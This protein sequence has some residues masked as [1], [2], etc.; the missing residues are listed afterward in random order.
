MAY[1]V[2][3]D[4]DP[5]HDDAA[6]ILLALANTDRFDIVGFSTVCG[7]AVLANTTMNLDHLLSYIHQPT[8]IH[9][10]AD[11]PL[12]VDP[13]PQLAHGV[14]GMDGPTFTKRDCTIAYDAI[15]ALR[16]ALMDSDEKLTIFALG[17]LTNIA[18]LIRTYPQ[19]I[20]HIDRLIIMGGAINGGNM[21]AC[22]EF[23]L[24]G[25]PHAAKIVFDSADRIDITLAPLEV[26]QACATPLERFDAF[27]KDG[28]LYDMLRPLFDFY[29]GYARV[30][31]MDR[32]PIFDMI[33]VAYALDPS[34]FT[35]I[36][37]PIDIIM[38][39]KHTRGMSVVLRNVS[40]RYNVK[41]LTDGDGQWVNDT[42]FNGMSKLNEMIVK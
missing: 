8:T 35:S 36:E 16:D 41:I 24:Y 26:C 40:N 31:Q 3:F 15:D 5:G 39:G 23:N 34:K 32:T 4:C 2:W 12:I 6:A 13:D 38:E 18:L 25:D 14:S 19:V 17:P 9:A 10:G 21:L 30:H 7:N 1:R 20:D 11:H 33:T 28:Y 42:F 29:C 37:H 22:S 27:N